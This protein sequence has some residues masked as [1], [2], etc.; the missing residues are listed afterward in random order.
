MEHPFKSNKVP[1]VNTP[2][3]S[4]I[5]LA[6]YWLVIQPTPILAEKILQQKQ[7]LAKQF[8]CADAINGKPYICLAKFKQYPIN[9]LL[10]C[11]KLKIIFSSKTPFVIQLNNYG[12]F[13]TH[14]IYL[15]VTTSSII[16]LVQSL[17]VLQPML[18]LDK[19]TKAHFI[20]EPYIAI[21]RKLNPQQYHKAWQL[22]A[23]ANFSAAFTVAEV[24]LL[25][26]PA[27]GLFTVVQKFKLQ[28]VKPVINSIQKNLF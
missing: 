11:N 19:Y 10:L 6:D 4:T 14:T 23:K 27:D 17:K 20:T 8:N 28:G 15:Q 25:K 21:V 7:Q 24:A 18:R 5:P 12:S 3:C 9:E 13:P 16:Q 2:G 26:K 1:P 22:Y